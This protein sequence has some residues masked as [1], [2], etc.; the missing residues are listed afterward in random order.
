MIL[1]G[2]DLFHENQPSRQT[3]HQTMAALREFTLGDGPLN[4]E[5]LSDPRDNALQGYK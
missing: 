5:L 2:G 4:L 3:M 1:L